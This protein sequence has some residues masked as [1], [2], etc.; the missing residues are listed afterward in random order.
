MLLSVLLASSGCLLIA[1]AG[2]TTHTTPTLGQQLQDLKDARDK[3]AISAQE[4]E[5]AKARLLE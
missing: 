1:P 5:K 2:K 3:G 4:Y